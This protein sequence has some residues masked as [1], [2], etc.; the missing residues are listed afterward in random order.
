MKSLIIVL[1]LILSHLT[2]YADLGS[3]I[4]YKAKFEL[5]NGQNVEGYFTCATYDTVS[6]KFTDKTFNKFIDDFFSL[7]S[8]TLILFLKFQPLIYPKQKDLGDARFPLQAVV[9]DDII[10]ITKKDILVSHFLG[11]LL[12]IGWK[13]NKEN[14]GFYYCQWVID[15]LKQKEIDLLQQKPNAQLCVASDYQDYYLLSYNSKIGVNE[16]KLFKKRL[17]SLKK[18]ILNCKE[19]NSFICYQRK[20]LNIK[21]E[22]R[23][24][25]VILLTLAYFD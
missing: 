17:I 4:R 22:L 16:L 18:T 7:H 20:Y 21:Q 8:D 9:S 12:P 15:E 25:N 24:K 3:C 6:F 1:L 10:K 23:E 13:L 11:C 14:L 19:S 2:I 5:K